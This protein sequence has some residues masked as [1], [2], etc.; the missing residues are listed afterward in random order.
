MTD[1][2]LTVKEASSLARCSYATMRM[3]AS[4]GELPFRK[5]GRS[6]RISRSALYRELGLDPP[7]D[8]GT[9]GKSK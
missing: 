9:D 3:L 2:L 7:D 8:P 1:K 6:W 5:V 4:A